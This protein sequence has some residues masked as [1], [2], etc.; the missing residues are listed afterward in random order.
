MAKV[1]QRHLRV[2]LCYRVTFKRSMLMK[3]M[4]PSKK[5]SPE[6]S[7]SR[8]SIFKRTRLG[9]QT[10][11]CTAL[12]RMLSPRIP[13]L[14]F[15]L[16]GLCWDAKTNK[17]SA[18]V[19]VQEVER[20]QHSFKGRVLSGRMRIQLLVKPTSGFHAEVF[21]IVSARALTRSRMLQYGMWEDFTFLSTASPWTLMLNIGT[22]ALLCV[23]LLDGDY[24]ELEM[25]AELLGV[26]SK[27][28]LVGCLRGNPRTGSITIVLVACLKNLKEVPYL[29]VASKRGGPRAAWSVTHIADGIM[30]RRLEGAS[31][32][33][34]SCF[35]ISNGTTLECL[36]IKGRHR[37][38]ALGADFLENA[39]KS[40]IPNHAGDHLP[41]IAEAGT[42]RVSVRNT[43]DAKLSFIEVPYT[44]SHLFAVSGQEGISI[45]LSFCRAS[46]VLF[47]A[48]SDSHHLTQFSGRVVLNYLPCPFSTACAC[49][50]TWF[51]HRLLS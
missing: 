41:Y 35:W 46:P 43:L 18:G 36:D 31:L 34:E 20:E 26:S 3:V 39:A 22:H 6:L 14:N 16:D 50:A 49:S 33:D 1:T 4:K 23:N 5:K 37:R 47:F 48:T 8:F 21:E 51:P 24:V 10:V 42:G 12:G 30:R 7:P 32:I 27:V 15:Y 28:K 38:S 11:G 9:K 13:R 45:P 40:L 25:P 44:M 19:K 29:L 2:K 17:E